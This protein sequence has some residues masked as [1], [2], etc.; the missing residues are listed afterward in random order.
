MMTCSCDKRVLA[1]GVR[2][3]P[4]G[5]GHKISA[6]L[7]SRCTMHISLLQSLFESGLDI[8]IPFAIVAYL[9]TDLA[10]SVSV[11]GRLILCHMF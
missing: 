10:T 2:R 4:L 9:D 3:A 8:L 11:R 7:I 5:S 6:T 1:E